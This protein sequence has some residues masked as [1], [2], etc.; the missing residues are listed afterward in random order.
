MTGFLG[1]LHHTGSA[2]DVDSK[3]GWWPKDRN[4]RIKLW[5]TFEG[6]YRGQGLRDR[7]K[8]TQAAKSVYRALL[9]D[10]LNIA[11]GACFP[12][13]DAIAAKAR[14]SRRAVAYALK[15]LQ[16]YDF[17]LWQPRRKIVRLGR[18][19]AHIQTSNA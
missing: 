17:L 19:S 13:Y 18:V 9:F 16:A 7:G 3:R 11:R 2:W 12:S 15:Q 1:A 4:Q 8:L 14:L 6:A 10:F 5:V